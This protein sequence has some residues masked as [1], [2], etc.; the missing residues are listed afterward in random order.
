MSTGPKSKPDLAGDAAGAI[1]KAIP[2]LIF[3]LSANGT[4][5]D[6]HASR[7]GDLLLRPEDFIGRTVG[8][9]MP[10]DIAAVYMEHIG[11][12]L[13]EQRLQTFDYSLTFPGGEVRHYE[14]R[15]VVSAPE[16]V[17][18]IVREITGRVRAEEALRESEARF[19]AFMDHTPAFAYIKNAALEHIYHNRSTQIALGD[20][21]DQPVRS[22]EFLSEEIACRVEAAD[23]RI[24]EGDSEL[25]QLV[26]Q[27]DDKGRMPPGL[28][29]QDLKFPITMP[30]GRRLV[31]GVAMDITQQKRI[32]ED[33]L[34]SQKLE[35]LGVL[36]GGIAHDFN[37]I[38]GSIL[39]HIQLATMDLDPDSEAHRTLAEARKAG[40][41]ATG[42]TRQLLTFAKG[43]APVKEAALLAPLVRDSADFAV[44]GSKV[45][46]EFEAADN[47]WVA[48]VDAGQ[49]SQVI[50]NLVINACQAMPSG[51]LVTIGLD[52]VELAEGHGASVP[53]GAGRYV[54]I[55]VRDRGHGIPPEVLSRIFDPYFTTKPEGSGLGLASCFSIVRRH[56]GWIAC[57]SA[58]GEGTVFTIHLPATDRQPVRHDTG[59]DALPKGAGRI[60]VVEDDGPLRDATRTMLQRLGYSAEAVADGAAGVALYRQAWEERRPY[61]AVMLDLTIPGGMGGKEALGQ[62]LQINPVAK[63]LV[64][65]GYS[66]DPV[67]ARPEEHGFRGVLAKPFTIEMLAQRLHAVLG[68][69]TEGGG[70]T[71]ARRRLIVVDDNEELLRMLVRRLTREGHSVEAFS[72]SP[73]ALAR[74]MMD[75]QAFDAVITD[76]AMG[77]LPGDRLASLI[78]SAAPDCPIVFLSGNLQ[79]LRVQHPLGLS[80]AR[81]ATLEKPVDFGVLLSTLAEWLDGGR[82]V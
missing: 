43:G 61:D 62:M 81:H 67:M 60:L 66:N 18:A 37:N 56:E 50:H 2:D 25:E 82:T 33:L 35:S 41:R 48:N 46:L 80:R 79:D 71:P 44:K 23:R 47:L 5:L 24:L 22:R 6:F 29:F 72:S 73:E 70:R 64:V 16:R 49:I 74:I 19:K 4:H 76:C 36:A 31:G 52:N 78:W 63:A 68:T 45:R 15:M 10:P 28:W 54:R 65:S 3:S 14:T 77:H 34:K 75:P 21:P 30:D 12:A 53:L 9:V 17:L 1:I 20:I 40:L 7:I 32:E 42:L 69:P 8:E 13:A 26:Y 38:L 59:P 27:T 51:G 57:E 55:T 11:R 39:G 58:V